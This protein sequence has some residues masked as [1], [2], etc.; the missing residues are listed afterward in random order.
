MAS[1]ISLGLLEAIARVTLVFLCRA[2]AKLP[3]IFV[4]Y[5]LPAGTIVSRAAS[6]S[7]PRVDRYLK[8]YIRSDASR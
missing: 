4:R 1:I 3:L 2:I 6:F 5:G 7:V 8:W